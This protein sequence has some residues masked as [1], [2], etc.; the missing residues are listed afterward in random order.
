MQSKAAT[1][2]QYIAELPADRREV[3]SAIR[4]VFLKN[5]EKGFEERMSYGMI[6]YCV[7][8]SIYPAGYHCDPRQPLPFA[9]VAAQKNAYSVYLFCIY[10]DADE[11][12]R[13]RKAWAAT[14]KKLDMGKSC[15]R[16][17]RLEDC[18]LDVIAETLKRVT[19]ESHIRQYEKSVPGA[20]GLSATAIESKPARSKTSTSRPDKKATAKR[21]AAKKA[22]AKKPAAKNPPAKKNAAGQRAAR[23]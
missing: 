23:R 18:A 4:R 2:D 10:A 13:F 19:V 11:G 9:G 12:M 3:V 22:T 7:P 6:G 14:G 1:V 16:F 5:L 8:H 15:I 21:N 20:A 17:K